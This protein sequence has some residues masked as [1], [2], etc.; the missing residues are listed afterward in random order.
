MVFDKGFSVLTFAEQMANLSSGNINFETLPTTGPGDVDRQGRARHRP[1]ADQ[2][3]LRRPSTA[4]TPSRLPARRRAPTVDPASVTVDVQDGTIADGVTEFAA[5]IVT[6]AGFTLGS[7]GRGG[8]HQVRARAADDR[9]AL[10]RGRRGRRA[11]GARPRSGV[12]ELVPDD[13][14][15]DRP[16]AGGR[17]HGPEGALR[18]A[19][20]GRGFLAAGRGRGAGSCGGCRAGGW[21][22]GGTGRS[23]GGAGRDSRSLGAMRELTSAGP[24][25]GS[26]SARR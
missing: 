22:G 19:L 10:R 8:R 13:A 5:D 24:I 4:A 2:G 12:G 20:A 7:A 26:S 23:G 14:V 9:G 25:P 18:T 11:A 17:R 15:T 3:V 1:G 16:R 6:K 21:S